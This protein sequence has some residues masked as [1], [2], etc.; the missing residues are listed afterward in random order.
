MAKS[1]LSQAVNVEVLGRDTFPTAT[2]YHGVPVSVF[3]DSQT[4]TI[5]HAIAN[6]SYYR[7]QAAASDSI[8]TQLNNVVAQ[9]DVDNLA[10]RQKFDSVSLQYNLERQN[11]ADL[12]TGLHASQDETKAV[13]KSFRLK[14][15]WA[16]PTTGFVF[17]GATALI[18][19]IR[20]KK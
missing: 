6:S 4:D 17:S 9:K 12:E 2:V 15:A 11:R 10:L 19:W 8:V 7:Q 5:A 1:G 18:C 16:I 13:K 14:M 20:W 3:T